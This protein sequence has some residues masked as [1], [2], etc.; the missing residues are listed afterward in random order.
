ME[1]KVFIRRE[2]VPMTKEEVRS[3]SLS[4]LQLYR[5]KSLLDVGAGSGSVVI[6]ALLN[7]PKMEAVAIEMK[8]DAIETI[9]L[10]IGE[11]EERYGAS[12]SGRLKVLEGKAPLRIKETF[13]AIFVGGTAGKVEELIDWTASLLNPEG[14]MVMNF[15]T[16]ENY[17]SAMQILKSKEEFTDFRGI[18]LCVNRLSPLASYTVLKPENPIWILSV[19]KGEK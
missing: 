9:R 14:I 18:Q 13:D 11:F 4:Y 19:K 7:F 3:V 8:P 1:D 12:L 15:V 17:Y 2:K 6:E 5:A 16:L 10:N